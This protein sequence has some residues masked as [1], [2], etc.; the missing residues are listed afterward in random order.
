MS[1]KN[2]LFAASM[3]LAFGSVSAWAATSEEST[4]AECVTQAEVDAMSDEAKA[5]LEVPVCDEA[6]AAAMEAKDEEEAKSD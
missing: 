6:T 2:L 1:I 5:N 4:D 3:L